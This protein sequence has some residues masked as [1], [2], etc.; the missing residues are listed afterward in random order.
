M[1]E[2]RLHLRDWPRSFRTRDWEL[3]DFSDDEWNGEH[4]WRV[5]ELMLED[6]RRGI[7]LDVPPLPAAPAEPVAGP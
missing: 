6:Q 1:V 7:S 4:R 5:V 3:A 2:D